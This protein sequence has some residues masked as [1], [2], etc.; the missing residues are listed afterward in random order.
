MS[1]FNVYHE[2]LF[3]AAAWRAR[4]RKIARRLFHAAGFAMTLITIIVVAIVIGGIAYFLLY[5]VMLHKPTFQRS[6]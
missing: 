6:G 2:N 5:G 3:L 1:L 4:C